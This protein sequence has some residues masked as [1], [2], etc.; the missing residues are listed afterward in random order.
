MSFSLKSVPLGSSVTLL[1]KQSLHILCTYCMQD[2]VK[3]AY[4]VYLL[5]AR[6]GAGQTEERDQTCIWGYGS[7]LTL[8]HEC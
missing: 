5:H 6:S 2:P 4:T 3:S 8:V 1:K 7:Y